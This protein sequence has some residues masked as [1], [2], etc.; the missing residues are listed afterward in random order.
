MK[1]LKNV[2]NDQWFGFKFDYIKSIRDVY[3]FLNAFNLV[4]ERMHGEIVIKDL[5]NI[6]LLRM[7]YNY[8]CI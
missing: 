3:R 2:I 8:L 7:K 5:M 6:E 1:N 4:Y